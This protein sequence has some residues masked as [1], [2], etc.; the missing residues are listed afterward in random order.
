M[1]SCTKI[2]FDTEDE[3]RTELH[4][5]V[6]LNDWRGWKRLTP[7]RYYYCPYCDKFHLTSK[8]TITKL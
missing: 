8:S 6:E 2:A 5:I 7:T 4:R 1:E 3:A